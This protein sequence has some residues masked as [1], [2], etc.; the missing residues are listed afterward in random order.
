MALDFNETSCSIPPVQTLIVICNVRKTDL[1]V[2]YTRGKT[3]I[4]T[5]ET[6]RVGKYKICLCN[7]DFAVRK[8]KISVKSDC[9]ISHVQVKENEISIT[10]EGRYWYTKLV[11]Y[12]N[13]PIQNWTFSYAVTQTKWIFTVNSTCSCMMQ[14]ELDI[15]C[16]L[17][18]K[19]RIG[20]IDEKREFFRNLREILFKNHYKN[21][22]T[23]DNIGKADRKLHWDPETLEGSGEICEAITGN[24]HTYIDREKLFKGKFI[25]KFVI[26]FS[27][28]IVDYR[29]N[30]G[31]LMTVYV[32]DGSNPQLY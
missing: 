11:N 6:I 26:H 1:K 21:W 19:H 2:H 30:D 13:T 17:I 8:L 12:K 28:G 27:P 5:S 4:A 16:G 22:Y 20:N 9:Y 23:T 29:I 24:Y 32:H 18:G 31:P 14:K 7:V 25:D 3:E 10:I 15:I